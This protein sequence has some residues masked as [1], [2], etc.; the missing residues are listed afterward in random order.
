MRFAR[1]ISPALLCV[2]LTACGTTTAAAPV[3]TTATVTAV[4]TVTATS[5]VTVKVTPTPATSAAAA[6]SLS[7]DQAMCLVINKALDYVAAVEVNYNK[8][9]GSAP[10]DFLQKVSQESTDTFNLFSGSYLESPGITEPLR[11]ALLTYGTQVAIFEAQGP[12]GVTIFD[13][14]M[15]SLRAVCS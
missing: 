15:A 6:G 7:S 12:D 9:D 10:L 1:L 8:Q 14:N 4:Q 11:Q 2:A 13:G 3:T 5:T